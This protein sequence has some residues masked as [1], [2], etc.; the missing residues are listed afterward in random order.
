MSNQ[1]M[2]AGLGLAIVLALPGCASLMQQAE[3]GAASGD[4]YRKVSS[5]ETVKMT[6]QE[7]SVFAATNK[8]RK[9][10]GLPELEPDA[11]LIAIARMRSADMAKRN[12]FS[13]ITPEGSDVFGL[14]RS[15]QV[16]F[17]AA[18]ENLARN[19]YS[20]AQAPDVAMQGWIKSAG[21]RA[22]LLHPSFGHL[23]VGLAVASD[24]KKYLTQV[25]TD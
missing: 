3:G 6:L 25:F 1:L 17:W 10:Q 18:G 24:G 12:Y 13:H 5:Q 11:R 9:A 4:G 23:G 16:R 8:Y 14:M 21:H 2:K 22:N 15:R 7:A 19:N 20:L